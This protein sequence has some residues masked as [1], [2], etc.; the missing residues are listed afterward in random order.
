[1]DEGEAKQERL[2]REVRFVGSSRDDLK[3]FPNRARRRSGFDLETVQRGE[4]PS[5]AKVLSG[6][7]GGGVQ[8]IVTEA[9]GGTYRVVYVVRLERAVYVLHAFQ[10]KSTLG[11]KT[12][13]R[14]M[15]L[16]RRRL[17]E[18]EEMDRNG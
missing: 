7:G 11:I 6:F 14:D 1:M 10:K 9:E 18:A 16:I 8:E 4:M 5:R 2:M 17:E 12:S 3:A 13:R 15:E